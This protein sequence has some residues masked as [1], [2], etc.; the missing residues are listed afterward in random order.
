MIIIGWP[1]CIVENNIGPNRLGSGARAT[2][3]K[4][5]RSR[6]FGNG[7]PD[8]HSPD[9]RLVALKYVASTHLQLSSISFLLVFCDFHPK[10]PSIAAGQTIATLCCLSL[11]LNR[12]SK[13]NVSYPLSQCAFY[14]Q[15]D[16]V[17]EFDAT[18]STP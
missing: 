3:K 15:S 4:K 8:S 9:Q 12:P 18:F 16:Q 11:F 1:G 10:R 2:T 6:H 17:K 5:R 13:H 7:R 14:N